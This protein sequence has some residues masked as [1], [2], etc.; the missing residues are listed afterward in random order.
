MGNRSSSW[1]F[2]P[3]FFLRKDVDEALETSGDLCQVEALRV[4]REVRAVRRR[5]RHILTPGQ[6]QAGAVLV[7]GHPFL[8][9]VGRVVGCQGHA[10]LRTPYRSTLARSHLASGHGQQGSNRQHLVAGRAEGETDAQGGPE[11]RGRGKSA[12]ETSPM[13]VLN[14]LLIQLATMEVLWDVCTAEPALNSFR[15][16]F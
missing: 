16:R 10:R 2:S 14:T 9:V 6:E 12:Q 15:T 11:L 8:V 5:V 1:L 7:G 4:V 3:C 13:H